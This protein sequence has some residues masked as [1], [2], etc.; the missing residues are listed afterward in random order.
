MSFADSAL[1]FIGH[2]PLLRLGRLCPNHAV[3]A[4]CEFM[5]PISVKDRPVMQI[6]LDAE[7]AGRLKPGDTLIECTSGNTGMAVAWI[8]AIRGYRA[9]LVMSEIQS[10]ERRQTMKAFGADL[11]LTPASEGTS[12]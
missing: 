12:G 1:D 5:N 3:F 10:L 2:T 8:S 6:I 7:R 11:V 4:K 9:V